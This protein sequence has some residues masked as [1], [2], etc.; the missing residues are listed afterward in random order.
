MSV[1]PAELT[2][3]AIVAELAPPC[4][5]PGVQHMHDQRMIG[6]PTLDL[7]DRRDAL[8][9]GRVRA[10]AIDRFGRKGDEVTLRKQRAC[11]GKPGGI[12]FQNLGLCQS[13]DAAFLLLAGGR[14]LPCRQFADI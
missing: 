10:Q 4:R 8:H 6:R 3:K 14:T 2:P 11:A 9:A 13:H 1:L 5:L 12:G 7:I